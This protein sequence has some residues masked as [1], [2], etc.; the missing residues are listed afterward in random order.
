MSS[1]GKCFV[2][3]MDIQKPFVFTKKDKYVNV[4]ISFG[5]QKIQIQF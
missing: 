1:V 5:L 2:L 4:S 3:L